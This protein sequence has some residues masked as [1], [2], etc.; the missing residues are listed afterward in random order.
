MKR[1]TK[2]ILEAVC[3]CTFLL[4]VLGCENADGSLNAAWT[5]PL[6]TATGLSGWILKRSDNEKDQSHD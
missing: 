2:L 6:L 1:K 4:A 3:V 5:L